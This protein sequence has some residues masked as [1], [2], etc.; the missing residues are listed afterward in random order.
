MLGR[1]SQKGGVLEGYGCNFT[2][3]S[4]RRPGGWRPQNRG[5]GRAIP[6]DVW[7]R[8]ADKAQ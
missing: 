6:K 4:Q 7:G 5:Q 2:Q 1:K 8:E 3:G